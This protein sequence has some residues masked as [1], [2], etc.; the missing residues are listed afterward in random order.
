MSVASIGSATTGNVF[1]TA[2]T[3]S[4]ALG[5]DQFLKLL[6]TQLRYQNPLEPLKDGEFIAQLAQFSGLDGIQQLNSSFADMLLLQQMTQGAN[7]IGKTVVY[8]RTDSTLPGRGT[9]QA[10]KVS[11]GVLQLQIDGKLVTLGQVRS[12]S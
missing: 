8:D 11:Q 12:I 3:A 5:K 1:G 9:V 6:A 2:G 10:V 7:L 4:Q